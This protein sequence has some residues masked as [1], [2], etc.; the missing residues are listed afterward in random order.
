MKYNAFGRKV[1]DRGL[2][3]ET[4]Y[5]ETLLC[6]T[7]PLWSPPLNVDDSEPTTCLTCLVSTPKKS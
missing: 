5:N 7:Q 2:V 4:H 1:S 6:D 3:H